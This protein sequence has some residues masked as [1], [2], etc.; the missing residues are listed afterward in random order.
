MSSIAEV[1]VQNILPIFFVAAFGFWLRRVK[2]VDVRPVASMVFNGFSPALVFTSLIN[3]QLPMGELAQLSLFALV[4]ILAMG[5]LGLAAG[6]ALHLSRPDTIVLLL[7]LMFV[8]SGNYGLT[9][10]QIRYG[11]VGLSRAIVYYT[12]STLVVYS[13]GVFIISMGNSDWRAALHRLV[14]IPA[15]YAVL[16]SIVFYSLQLPVPGPVMSALEVA[17]A[18]AIPAMIVVLGMNI[19]ELPGLTQL[20]LTIPAVSLRLVVGPFVALGI[21]TW[22][23]LQGLNRSTAIIEASMPTAV[24]TTVL[25]TEFDVKPAVVTSIV[26]L[27]TVLSP[28]TLA[29]FITLFNL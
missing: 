27:S 6:R 16:L 17:A 9:L 14:R 19:A 2:K 1:L 3:S 26:V 4:M 5:A 15:F 22:V 23:G 25:A 13:L 20:R 12:V 8:N 18:G 11:D 10:N 29:L 7:T 24:L 28:I 21:A